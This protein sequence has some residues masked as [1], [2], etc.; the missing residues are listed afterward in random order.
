MAFTDE[1]WADS[2]EGRKHSSHAIIIKAFFFFIKAFFFLSFFLLAATS[3]SGE[4]SLSHM[5]V[6]HTCHFASEEAPAC[7][8]FTSEQL[9]HNNADLSLGR[10][11]H[12]FSFYIG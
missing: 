9:Q 11:P 5:L 4:D 6:L 8:A 10:S 12:C 2:R 7:H 1:A 3:L